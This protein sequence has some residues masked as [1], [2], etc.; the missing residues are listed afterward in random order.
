M[1]APSQKQIDAEIARLKEMKPN[2]RETSAFGNNHHD[3]IDAQLRVLQG[4]VAEDDFD[5]EFEEAEDNVRDG[6][7]R[8]LDWMNGIDPN[9]PSSEWKELLIK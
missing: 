8:A 6:A 4:E 7:Q 3:A 5:E 9:A 2:V 1:K